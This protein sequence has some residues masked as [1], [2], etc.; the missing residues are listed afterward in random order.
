MFTIHHRQTQEWTQNTT[1]VVKVT[2]LTNDM[3]MKWLAGLM[4]AGD[5]DGE[6]W[7]VLPE[8]G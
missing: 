5:G 4:D 8:V 2:F 1:G 7:L 3:L 6:V